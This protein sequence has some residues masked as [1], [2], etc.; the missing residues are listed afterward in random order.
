MNSRRRADTTQAIEQT[1]IIWDDSKIRSHYPNLLN[2]SGGR[3]EIILSF[4]GYQTWDVGQ[5]GETVLL[6]DRIVMS[7]FTAKRLVTLLNNIIREYD[8]K[9]GPLEKDASP[10]T[11]KGP[12]PAIRQHF[13]I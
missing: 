2:V 6:S 3:E 7:P 4:G 8:S 10:S 5:D 1:R 9:Y 13:T 11:V 12:A